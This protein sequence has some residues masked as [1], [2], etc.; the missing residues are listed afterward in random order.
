MRILYL[1]HDFAGVGAGFTG[2]SLVRHLA[3]ENV[4]LRRV[5]AVNSENAEV[6]AKSSYA[7]EVIASEGVTR[8]EFDALI[9]E[10]GLS[11]GDGSPRIPLATI[12]SFVRSGGQVL[13][14]DVTRDVA[15]GERAL[16]TELAA[17]T[18]A[19]P[20]YDAAGYPR[21]QHDEASRDPHTGFYS[22]FASEMNVEDWRKSV[23]V[24]ID[25]VLV[26][27]PITLLVQSADWLATGNTST[28]VLEADRVVEQ[29][30]RFPWASVRQVGLGHIA[31][32]GALITHDL[33][34]EECPDNARWISAVLENLVQRTQEDQQW[35]G[36]DLPSNWSQHHE[37]LVELLGRDEDRTLERKASARLTVPEGMPLKTLEHAI[38]KTVVGFMNSD[39]GVLLIGVEDDGSIIG[40][41]RE[42]KSV[43]T[44]C[45]RDAYER[46]LLTALVTA[47]RDQAAINQYV[48]IEWERVEDHDVCIVG[49][50]AAPR[51]LF[52]R[53]DINGKPAADQFY[54][55]QGNATELFGVADAIAYE[56]GRFRQR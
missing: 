6:W 33:L 37:E 54:V 17:L 30:F 9:V 28:V 42:Y 21:Y 29:G 14:C 27:T 51:P 40:V 46:W 35:R 41:E 12:E 47:T 18:S 34:V 15:R 24:G 31:I 4:L 1:A 55:R 5:A 22:F 49:C 13:V 20:E 23:L 36:D 50:A 19:L 53:V 3:S 25:H 48:N 7:N 56:R 43:K 32:I 10:G 11:F 45:D 44:Q 16:L 26:G 2:R 39:G 8:T 38:F 52:V